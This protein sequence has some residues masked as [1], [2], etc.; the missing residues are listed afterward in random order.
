MLISKVTISTK[1]NWLVI[2]FQK[3]TDE[4][5]YAHSVSPYFKVKVFNK[6]SCNFFDV[7]EKDMVGTY[8]GPIN[9]AR[10]KLYPH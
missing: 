10:Y 7:W 4:R 2:C 3:L 6:T 1:I 8:I 9:A 5:C